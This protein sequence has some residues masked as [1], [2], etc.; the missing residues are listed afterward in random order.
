MR[1]IKGKKSA[2]VKV[3]PKVRTYAVVLDSAVLT[4]AEA[5]AR[6][7]KKAKQFLLDAGIITKSGNLTANY[8]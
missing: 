6:D 7:P 2:G 5:I 8:K 1:A 3:A 4:H